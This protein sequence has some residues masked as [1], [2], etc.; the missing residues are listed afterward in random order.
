MMIHQMYMSSAASCF[1]VYPL[2]VLGICFYGSAQSMAILKGS[3]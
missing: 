2:V 3:T 1:P